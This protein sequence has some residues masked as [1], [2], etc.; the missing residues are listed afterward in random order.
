MSCRNQRFYS[1]FKSADQV[2]QAVLPRLT[3]HIYHAN[4]GLLSFNVRTKVQA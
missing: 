1:V 2:F 3:P 4:R